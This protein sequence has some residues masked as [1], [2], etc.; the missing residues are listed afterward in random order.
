MKF[1]SGILSGVAELHA[2]HSLVHRDLKPANILL[3]LDAMTP[4]IADLGAVKKLDVAHEYTS[5]SKATFYYLPPECII[6]KRYYFQS[7]LY[8]VGLILFQ[9]LGGF[10]PIESPFKWLTGREV[11][12]LA[13]I[14]N[15]QKDEFIN[16]LIASK[17]VIGK[18]ADT[19]T[20]PSYLDPA[21]KRLVN[22]AL[23]PDVDARFQNASEFLKAVGKLMCIYPSYRRTTDYLHVVHDSGTEYRILQEKQEYFVERRLEGRQWRKDKN[24]DNRIESVLSR[25][26]NP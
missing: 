25:A 11:K 6:D 23:N 21:F 20:L 22:K 5:E 26:R 12:R 14:P 16:E 8:Q 24:H 15:N 4:I 18:L 2:N 17:I 13:S 7:D 10:F 9:L 1:T 3:D 19:S